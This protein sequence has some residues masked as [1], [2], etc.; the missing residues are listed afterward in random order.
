MNVKKIIARR[1]VF[2]SLLA[3]C[4]LLFSTVS[5]AYGQAGQSA[6]SRALGT[7]K[8]ISGQTLILKTDSGSEITVN[9][10]PNTRLLRVEPGQ[11]TLAN[12]QS[13]AFSDLQ[14]GDRL[15]VRG[16][17]S[18]DGKTMQARGIIAM[19]KLDIAERR[20]HEREEW[21]KSGVGGLVKSVDPATA[22]IVITTSSLG[23]IKDLTIKVTGTTILRRYALNSVK[24]D[25]AK[26]APIGEIKPGDQLRARGE[27]GADGGTLTAD[28]IVSGTFRNIAGT[29]SSVDTTAKTLLVHDL[30]TKSDVIVHVTPD[31]QMR[32]LPPELAQ[33]IAFRLKGAAHP[34]AE[35][36]TRPAGQGM[37]SHGNGA[38][39]G[40]DFQ[41]ILARMPAASLSD[42]HKGDAVKIV[43]TGSGQ[44]GQVT[45]ITLLSGV[46]PI[47][48][49]SPKG[50]RQMVLSP[51]SLGAGAAEG[52]DTSAQTP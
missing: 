33:R 7:V 27:R 52:G 11:K 49:A 19:K 21:A 12:A 51:W 35:P 28:E 38:E 8:S 39:N 32:K 23:A 34:V 10:E 29:V 9:I 18:A 41:R 5:A 44:N 36:A 3:A 1:L 4:A 37:G 13:L 50:G 43:A 47:L 40:G 14:P 2:A 31:F 22:T 30:A 45:A 42:L 24:F 46:E 15:L 26:P 20:A 48:E 6:F 17:L 25:E 16:N